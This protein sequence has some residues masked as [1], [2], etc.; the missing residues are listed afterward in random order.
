MPSYKALKRTSPKIS[1][2]HNCKCL[3]IALMNVRLRMWPLVNKTYVG[4]KVAKAKESTQSISDILKEL[5]E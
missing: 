5:G 2:W 1:I 3:L 4:Y